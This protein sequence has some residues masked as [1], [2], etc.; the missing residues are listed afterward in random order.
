MY[1][2]AVRTEEQAKVI[3]IAAHGDDRRA[4]LLGGVLA[5]ICIAIAIVV[6]AMPGGDLAVWLVALFFALLGVGLG[7]LAYHSA[8]RSELVVEDGVLRAR[9][10]LLHKLSCPVESLRRV[11]GEIRAPNAALR[12]AAGLASG[13]RLPDQPLLV[14]ELASHTEELNV[15][16]YRRS[17][18]VIAR[19]L[20]RFLRRGEE[21]LRPRLADIDAQRRRFAEK[22]TVTGSLAS[23]LGG[24]RIIELDSDGVH[25]GNSVSRLRHHPW[26]SIAAAHVLSV[27]GGRIIEL[28]LADGGSVQLQGSYDVP[29]NDLAEMLSPRVYD[30]E[31]NRIRAAAEEARP[32][33]AKRKKRAR[34]RVPAE[35]E[36]RA[37]RDDESL[38]E[39][40]RVTAA[41][42]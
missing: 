24:A 1:R 3:T 38:E 40:E 2:S 5:A 25:V 33:K 10:A 8:R 6:A 21:S 28:E 29:L 32:R 11:T 12:L 13:S 27:A 42:R 20:R 4:R 22:V 19:R 17:P 35:E 26:S 7:A 37:A 15:A 18:E 41:R 23:R 16:V 14:L 36:A 31:G 9:G 30:E 34:L 39:E